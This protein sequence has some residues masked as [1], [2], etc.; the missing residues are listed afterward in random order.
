MNH[1][2]ITPQ[3]RRELEQYAELP[4]TDDEWDE[5][6]L[7]FARACMTIPAQEMTKRQ[8]DKS[9]REARRI[10]DEREQLA[11]RTALE[12]VILR[13]IEL[14]RVKA[15]RNTE[16]KAVRRGKKNISATL[17]GGAIIAAMYAPKVEAALKALRDY[18]KKNPG[19]SLTAARNRIAGQFCISRKTLERHAKKPISKK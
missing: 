15:A 1:P 11:P 17:S 6:A 10:M 18:R 7:A 19:V 16:A 13:E 4:C 2:D 8:R 5:A 3:R 9:E 12:L 14:E